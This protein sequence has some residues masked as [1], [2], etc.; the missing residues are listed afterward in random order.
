MA[1][2]ISIK[3]PAKKDYY[4][5]SSIVNRAGWPNAAFLV[6]TGDWRFAI[7]DTFEHGKK[8]HQYQ[9]GAG[10]YWSL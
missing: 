6:M 4:R 2:T 9:R 5:E 10:A 8:D 1:S 3:F 7:F